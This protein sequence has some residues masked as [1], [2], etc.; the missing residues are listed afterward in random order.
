MLQ[1]SLFA[2]LPHELGYVGELRIVAIWAIYPP[3]LAF[4]WHAM[5]LVTDE[6]CG[7]LAPSHKC[8]LQLLYLVVL[9][10]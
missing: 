3:A 7:E 10:Q 9:G 2:S 5:A 1:F 6:V 8:N 4:K